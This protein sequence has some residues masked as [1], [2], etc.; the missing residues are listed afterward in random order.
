MYNNYNIVQGVILWSCAQVVLGTASRDPLPS[1]A[2]VREGFPEKEVPQP[3]LKEFNRKRE[4]DRE[5]E[6]IPD[7]ARSL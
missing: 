6:C 3:S 2:D 5:E 1:L 4:W 7:K